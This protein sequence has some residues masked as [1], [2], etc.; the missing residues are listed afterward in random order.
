V[1]TSDTSALP[2][3]VGDA[4]LLVDPLA[5]DAIADGMIRL[6][7]DEALRTRLVDSGAVRAR[8]FGW[9]AVA[10]RTAEVYEE[11]A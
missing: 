9:D 4:A 5:T 6:L 10:A 11:I 7:T 3:T 2:E 8:N 1:L